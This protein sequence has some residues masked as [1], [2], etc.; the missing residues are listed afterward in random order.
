ME[1]LINIISIVGFVLAVVA[2]T[3]QFMQ[4]F[5]AKPKLDVTFVADGYS[6]DGPEARLKIVIHN[7]PVTNRLL[8]FFGIQ[9]QVVHLSAKFTVHDSGGNE[10]VRGD[11]FLES[12]VGSGH[13]VDLIE[14]SRSSTIAVTS[15]E[16]ATVVGRGTDHFESTF[17]SAE[18]YVYHLVLHTSRGSQSFKRRFS[19]GAREDSL[20]WL[21]AA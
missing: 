16:R 14:N 11:C 20:K 12:S 21:P 13:E 1:M 6:E 17:L 7:V 3:A 18:D 4:A 5:G 8:A 19:V 2:V 15:D 10:L 9:R